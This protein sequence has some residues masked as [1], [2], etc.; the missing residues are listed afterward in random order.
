MNAVLGNHYARLACVLLAALALRLGAGYAWQERLGPERRFA[1][2]D[3]D[4]Y[5]TL[6]RQIARGEPYQYGSPD[7]R[8][9][10]MPGYPLLLAGLFK[11]ADD[12]PSV[13]AGRALG[14]ILGTLAVAGVYGL[15]R[16]LFDP[17]TGLVAAMLAAIYPGAIGASVFILSEAPFCPLLLAQLMAAVASWQ[18]RTRGRA[19]WLAAASG[20]LAGLATLVRPSWLL[21]VPF[22]VV[23]GLALC[24][25]SR[26]D[27]AF[28]A[29]E[30][31]TLQG[32][33]CGKYLRLGSIAL[34]ALVLTMTPW[35]IRN[36][37]VTG[38]FV[39]TTL[40]V[41]A[42]LYDG[43]NPRADGS[44]EMSFVAQFERQERAAEAAAGAAQADPFE[45]RLD[46][47]LRD[48]ALGW[49]AAHPGKALRLAA[50]KVARVWNVWPNDAQFRN[51]AVRW[52][53][54][55][56]FVP[57]L[58]LA[59]WQTWKVRR[60]G[61]P[62]ALVWLPAIYVT[63]LHTVFVSSIRYREPAMLC[64]LPLAA[65]AIAQRISPSSAT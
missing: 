10:R 63:L 56:T 29:G 23:A 64:L 33:P 34:V 7:A 61:W 58:G 44:S 26:R 55:L 30:T 11:L 22:A 31:P 57:A 4:A 5:W 8:V 25:W 46:R 39:P 17:T 62:I 3:S 18:S 48:A 6:G 54:F 28:S 19:A 1:F 37:Q 59:V 21:F 50:V 45:V 9:F 47:R 53:V 40:Q 60:L 52:G 20:V 2:G 49:A 42:S 24:A 15:G 13:L 16:Q 38:R 51:P 14:A 41:G 12:E 65:A 27:S 35:W 43:L 36:W 32:S